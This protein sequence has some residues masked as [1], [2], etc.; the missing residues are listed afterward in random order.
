MTSWNNTKVHQLPAAKP[1]LSAH[2][3]MQEVDKSYNRQSF[4]H[5]CYKTKKVSN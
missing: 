2:T 5:G 4:T 3:T 1:A